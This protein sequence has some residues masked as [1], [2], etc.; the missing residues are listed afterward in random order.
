MSPPYHLGFVCNGLS[1]DNNV[2]FV[3]LTCRTKYAFYCKKLSLETIYCKTHIDNSHVPSNQPYSLH[4]DQ[5]CWNRFC[6]KVEP[7][8]KEKQ[9]IHWKS[10]ASPN[11]SIPK[12]SVL[13]S[14]P[15]AKRCGIFQTQPYLVG[16][17]NPLKNMKVNSDD[18]I[19][20]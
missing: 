2:W 20:N 17:L 13:S 5:F 9:T 4:I 1:R 19:P 15:Q 6:N 10:Q 12:T 11:R 16:G 3:L 18:D 7:G 8:L 14:V